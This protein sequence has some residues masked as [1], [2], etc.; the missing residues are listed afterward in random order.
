MIIPNCTSIYIRPI[1]SFIF[2]FLNNPPP[3]NSSPL[4]LPPPLPIPPPR[5]FCPPPPPQ[6]QHSPNSRLKPLIFAA[7]RQ[8]CP[9]VGPRTTDRAVT[10]P[11]CTSTIS[12]AK[13]IP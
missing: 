13:F 12:V 1:L 6:F 3:T 4:P 7:C 5:P 2:F 11:F 9:V 8:N 10:R